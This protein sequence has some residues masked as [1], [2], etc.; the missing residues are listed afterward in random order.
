MEY[1]YIYS[2]ALD[3]IEKRTKNNSNFTRY[4][5]VCVMVTDK[6]NIFSAFNKYI[7]LENNQIE[8]SCAEKEVLKIMSKTNENKIQALVVVDCSTKL[9][10][11]PCN[12]CKLQ[13][14]NINKDNYNCWIMLP[15]K[16]F[17]KLYETYTN[18]TSE[19]IN[20]VTDWTEGWDS[21]QP[22]KPTYEKYTADS[23][24]SLF[25]EEVKNRTFVSSTSSTGSKGS[26]KYSRKTSFTSRNE[27][28]RDSIYRSRINSILEDSSNP[29]IDNSKKEVKNDNQS[30][31][32]KRL[33]QLIDLEDSDETTETS[34]NN[35]ET[36]KKVVHQYEYTKKQ[37]LS[38]AKEKK[39]QAKKDRK[40]LDSYQQKA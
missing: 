24:N 11:I 18:S 36:P 5:T 30:L 20:D 16:T 4:S 12:D 23:T 35:V 33:S 34:S 10:I 40:I 21:P 19:N 14:L 7:M 27:N 15:D 22:D 8:N 29:T 37:L 2:I 13:I 17:S 26:S 39:K 25:I 1:E 38:M 32:R 9:P 31:L 6:G 3:L 28:S